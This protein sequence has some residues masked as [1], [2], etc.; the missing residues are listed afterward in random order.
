MRA[1]AFL[2]ALALSL[3]PQ[4]SESK[5]LVQA[6]WNDVPHLDEATK[7]TLLA[8]TMPHEREAR[9]KGLP[10]LGS[11]AIY[12]IG[13][14]EFVVDPF[15]LPVYW[16]RAYGLDVGWNWTAAIWGAWDRESD[17]V[18]V[19]TEHYRGQA[20][21]SVHVAGIKARG[22]WI[23]GVIDPAAAGRSQKDGSQLLE[24]Y[25]ALGLDLEP[26]EHAVESGLFSVWERLST[27]RL[28]VFRSCENWLKEFRVYRRDERGRIV[29]KFD[30]C[31]HPNT[32]VI[33]RR[34]R[35][36]IAD[37]VGSV[38]E[39]LTVDGRWT[40]Y[41][42]CRRTA[43]DQAV[44]RVAFD[45][46]STVVCTPDH[47][48]LTEHGWVEAGDL[49]GLLCYDAVSHRINEDV[50]AP[51]SFPTRSRSSWV[52]AI[53]SAATISSARV[54]AF[55]ASCGRA[56][57][58]AKSLTASTF[59][60]T[61]RIVPTTIPTTSSFC[62]APSTLP[63]TRLATSAAFLLW[64]SK[65]PRLGTDLSRDL[66]GIASTTPARLTSYSATPASSA[67][68]APPL[69]SPRHEAATGSAATAA[70][71]N[72]ADGPGSTMSTACAP[73]AQPV[74]ASTAT[75][76]PSPAAGPALRRCLSVRDA[77]RSDV[78][79]LTVPETQ[80]FAVEN[81]VVV[82]NC[83]DATRYLIASGIDRAVVEPQKRKGVGSAAGG[84]RRLGY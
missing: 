65:P 55:I 71:Q 56:L 38:G 11:G 58:A 60:M 44:V 24:D 12:P 34:G 57:T 80:A 76:R 1:V 69:S 77:G 19:Y 33:T 62:P 20:E 13:E 18:Y 73:N 46:G 43:E 54:S 4:V 31:L 23:P 82:H 16:P 45:D 10:S 78:Y 41:H 40:A 30:H 21:P 48:F 59:T 63:C 36:P 14:S 3:M 22:D 52:C 74:S 17:T 9:S 83:M 75:A 64:Q 6:G 15:Q 53:T 79:C 61:T 67:S 47:R 25:Q 32:L 51:P 27:G 37:L 39:V 26:A 50:C 81:G 8:S 28:K 29:K 7:R 68:S 2:L 42:N 35:Y 5:Y 49:Q 70:S 84:D 66:L 72:G